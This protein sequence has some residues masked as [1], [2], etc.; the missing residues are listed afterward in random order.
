MFRRNI[1]ILDLIASRQDEFAGFS[2]R[3]ALVDDVSVLVQLNV[4][5]ADNVFVFHP[6]CQVERIRLTT[7]L[8][9]I[10][11]DALVSAINVFLRHMIARFEFCVATIDD[12]DKFDHPAIHDFAIWRFDKSKRID[13]RIARQRR[14]QS[15]VWS[16]RRFDRT[17][18]SVVSRV[19]VA[20]LESRALAAQASRP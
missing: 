1:D 17:N 18:A 12:P 8:L 9:A 4:R 5:L 10:R 16:F 14:N 7:C 13:P 11:T 3:V 15:D 19:D 6:G 2:R 20:H